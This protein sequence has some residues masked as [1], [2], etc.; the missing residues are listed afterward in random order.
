MPANNLMLMF[1]RSGAGLESERRGQRAARRAVL[2]P[3]HRAWKQPRPCEPA[4]RTNRLQPHRLRTRHG[5]GRARPVRRE[6][7]VRRGGRPDPGT[8]R[9]PIECDASAVGGRRWAGAGGRGVRGRDPQCD[10]GAETGRG[11]S[12]MAS[13][14]RADRRCCASKTADASAARFPARSPRPA[15]SVCGPRRPSGSFRAPIP[16]RWEASPAASSS[17][18]PPASRR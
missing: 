13:P 14:R 4:G 9:H 11:S 15:G 2:G 6:R 18:S 8:V 10:R 3:E 17:G 5:R 12:S 7:H 16:T 1:A